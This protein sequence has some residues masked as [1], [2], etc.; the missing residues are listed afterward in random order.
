[1]AIV[2]PVPRGAVKKSRITVFWKKTGL[3]V[4]AGVPSCTGTNY[5]LICFVNP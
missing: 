2:L 5:N 4:L 1:M 3:G